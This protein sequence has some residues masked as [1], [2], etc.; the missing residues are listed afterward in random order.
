MRETSIS[1]GLITCQV[2]E[3]RRIP[4]RA[5]FDNSATAHSAA[6]SCEN[7]LGDMLRHDPVGSRHGGNRFPASNSSRIH[8]SLDIRDSRHQGSKDWALMLTSRNSEMMTAADLNRHTRNHWGIENKNH[9]VCDTVYH[10]RGDLVDRPATNWTPA[11]F[12][13]RTTWASS[14]GLVQ[15]RPQGVTTAS[16]PPVESIC[17]HHAH[18][19]SN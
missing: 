5:V 4:Q 10:E 7:E 15:D 14:S 12:L 2:K 11:T 16:P 1:T 6:T 17:P 9:Y 8:P 13:S 3:S 19:H 18:M